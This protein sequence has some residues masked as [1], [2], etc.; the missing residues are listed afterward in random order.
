MF[1]FNI[2]NWSRS[3]CHRVRCAFVFCWHNTLN[4]DIHCKFFS[5]FYLNQQQNIY[6]I[7][8]TRKGFF[9]TNF[10]IVELLLQRQ[11]IIWIAGVWLFCSHSI[12]HVCLQSTWISSTTIYTTFK[13]ISLSNS[14]IAFVFLRSLSIFQSIQQN[15]FPFLLHSAAL[16]ATA[17]SNS[18]VFNSSIF[19][20]FGSCACVSTY[21]LLPLFFVSIFFIPFKNL[22]IQFRKW[23]IENNRFSNLQFYEN[24]IDSVFV[25]FFAVV[26]ARHSLCFSC[27]F[28]DD[29]KLGAVAAFTKCLEMEMN[30]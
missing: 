9:P 26:V 17:I 8:Y 25:H 11:F 19:F 23:W 15:F 16:S 7:I 20:F 22:S 13:L 24:W 4:A 10:S 29:N 27:D 5:F 2:S 3:F 12:W 6:N 18:I 14:T 21:T 28:T 30:Y 1:T